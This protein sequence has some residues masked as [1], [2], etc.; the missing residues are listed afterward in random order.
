[1]CVNLYLEE[2]KGMVCT[3]VTTAIAASITVAAVVGLITLLVVREV[4]DAS[5]RP[6]LKLLGRH[7]AAFSIPLLVVLVFVVI[8]HMLEIIA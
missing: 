3:V 8:M 4:A 5:K 1:M 2:L 7:L 6:V